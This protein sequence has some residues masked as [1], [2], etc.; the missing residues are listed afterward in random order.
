MGVRKIVQDIVQDTENSTPINNKVNVRII[1]AKRRTKMVSLKAN[2]I[3][4]FIQI[5]GTVIRVSNV[6]PFVISMP[7]ECD[8]CGNVVEQYF[9]DG[10]YD[11]PKSCASG[12]CRSRRLNPMRS[13][14][15]TV[16][17]QYIKLQEEMG[18]DAAGRIPRSV[19]CEL[20]EDLVNCCVPG[21]VVT[22]NGIVKVASASSSTLINL[23]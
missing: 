1:G 10:K 7:F 20:T 18:D 3:G 23:C 13:D 17:L 2:M 11:N 15:H 5:R 6:Q 21:D 19:E 14:A 22:V 16:D 4:K 8:G 12:N 9:L